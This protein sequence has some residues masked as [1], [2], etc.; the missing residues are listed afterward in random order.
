MSETI[1]ESDDNPFATIA[2]AILAG[3]A[4]S[5]ARDRIITSIAVV[6]AGVAPHEVSSLMHM[7]DRYRPGDSRVEYLV[8][9]DH[10]DPN[11]RELLEAVGMAGDSHRVVPR[12]SGG[13]AVELDALTMAAT[14]EFVVVLNGS[15]ELL[16][17]L[18]TALG[19]LWIHGGDAA[20]IRGSVGPSGTVDPGDDAA[21][22]TSHLG[23]AAQGGEHLVVLRRWVARW[24]LNEMD[25]ALDPGAEFADRARLLGLTLVE[26]DHRGLPV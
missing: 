24:L 5:P 20:S 6:V 3:T 2:E 7:V 25:R 4:P 19:S 22:L 14:S 18:E 13:W 23:L 15:C 9:D 10:C 21:R 11:R 12:P 1:H 26:L 8:L 17:P 16:C